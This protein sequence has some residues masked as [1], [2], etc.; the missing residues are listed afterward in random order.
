MLES[1]ANKASPTKHFDQFKLPKESS[2][3][4]VTVDTNMALCTILFILF[5]P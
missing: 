4:K 2:N 5:R 1:W 3:M